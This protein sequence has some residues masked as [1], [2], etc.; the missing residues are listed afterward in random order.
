MVCL[1]IE[2]S[3]SGMSH[4]RALSERSMCFVAITTSCTVVVF[5]I[6]NTHV[7]VLHDPRNAYSHPYGVYANCLCAVVMHS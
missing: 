6:Y 4:D 1:M 5:C 7:P 2:L 3:L